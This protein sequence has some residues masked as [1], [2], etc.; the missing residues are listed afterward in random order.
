MLFLNLADAVED[1]GAGRFVVDRR[2]LLLEEANQVGKGATV[3]ELLCE[4]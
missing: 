3:F 2:K 4:G 1:A